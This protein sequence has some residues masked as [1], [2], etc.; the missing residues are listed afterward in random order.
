M[1]LRKRREFKEE[2]LDRTLW[3]TRFGSGCGPI[4][5]QTAEWMNEW[6]KQVSSSEAELVSA[7]F[8][9]LNQLHADRAR[10]IAV[11]TSAA[12]VSLF[13]F[14]SLLVLCASNR[15]HHNTAANPNV[16]CG[17][18]GSGWMRHAEGGNTE[19]ERPYVYRVRCLMSE[20]TT[21]HNKLMIQITTRHEQPEWLTNWMTP[22]RRVFLEKLIVLQLVKKKIP[23]NLWNQKVYFRVHRCLIVYV[24]QIN[25]I[26]AP[27]LCAII[28]SSLHLRLGIPSGSFHSQVDTDRQSFLYIHTIYKNICEWRLLSTCVPPSQQ[29]VPHTQILSF[30][31]HDQTLYAFPFSFLRSIRPAHP[32]TLYLITLITLFLI[33]WQPLRGLDRVIVRGFTITL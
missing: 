16:I 8:V 31:L 27:S 6:I 30:S 20:D 29:D 18:C 12:M 3:R 19:S 33:A 13:I 17:G 4:V 22:W 28:V 21:Q 7:W 26:H 15:G 24:S 1:T 23:R 10:T 11:T 5:R 32:N 2:A 14:P 25:P 9:S